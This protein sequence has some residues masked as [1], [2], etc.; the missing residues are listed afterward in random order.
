M[1][2]RYALTRARAHNSCLF[3]LDAGTCARRLAVVAARELWVHCIMPGACGPAREMRTGPGARELRT[4]NFEF[5]SAWCIF[6]L[7]F[8]SDVTWCVGGLDRC[9][10]GLDWSGGRRQKHE[11]GVK[12]F[13][14][15]LMAWSL[16]RST[17]ASVA[18]G[19]AIKKVPNAVYVEHSTS[20]VEIPPATA[21][22]ECVD[23][24]S[25]E[26]ER[27]AQRAAQ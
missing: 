4:S 23:S 3:S 15:T 26:D 14:R 22:G 27:A 8:Q 10:R 2:F 25:A 11:R 7:A 13:L 12:L 19:K 16:S 1:F 20:V 21:G 17:R 9:R 5:R 6:M 18:P 24:E